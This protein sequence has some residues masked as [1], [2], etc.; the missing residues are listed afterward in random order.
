MLALCFFGSH[1]V[2]PYIFRLFYCFSTFT[3]P[4]HHE[5]HQLW[6]RRRARRCI[7]RRRRPLPAL[8]AYALALLRLVLGQQH[9]PTRVVV[10]GLD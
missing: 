5:D 4:L 8:V 2:T 9:R 7:G 10:V 3:S 6:R 1:L